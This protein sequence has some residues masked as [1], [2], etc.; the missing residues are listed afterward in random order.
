MNST[1][2]EK[3]QFDP[4]VAFMVF[5]S[6]VKA[7]QVISDQ[8]GE[9]AALAFFFAIAD[10]SMYDADPDFTDYPLLEALWQTIETEID[11]SIT[12]RKRGFAKDMMNEKYQAIIEAIAA[13]PSAPLRTIAELTDT[14]KNMVQRVRRK[15]PELIEAAIAM[16]SGC[17]TASEND[18]KNPSDLDREQYSASSHTSVDD[19]RERY[20]GHPPEYID[21]EDILALDDHIRYYDDGSEL[22]IY[23]D[24]CP[25]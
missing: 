6:W 18:F 16:R 2:I 3:K 22:C 7:I 19:S 17:E 20:M 12:R 5:G 24:D 9:S 4:S 25:F 8:V 21:E 10:Y 15:Y 11:L 13:N 1:S 14:N 23:N